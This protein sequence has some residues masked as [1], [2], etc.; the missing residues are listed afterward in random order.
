MQLR[1]VIAASAIGLSIACVTTLASAQQVYKWT[2]ASGTIHFSQTPPANGTHYSKMRLS[3][4]SGV[5]SVPPAASN[6]EPS[7]ESA[8]EGATRIP[9]QAQGGQTDTPENRTKLCQQLA[10]NVSLLEG[11]QPVV[12][13][14]TNGDQQV[15]SDDARE[16]QLA[17]ARA[18]QAQ[19]CANG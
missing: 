7:R 5:S 12:T 17:T 8:N 2:D 14:G 13:A 3:N 15:M 6:P 16:K 18:R 4:A 19:Y 11:K 9:A 1:T 10:S